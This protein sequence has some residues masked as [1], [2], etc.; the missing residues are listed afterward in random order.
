[1][2][3]SRFSDSQIMA[4]LKQAEND[5]AVSTLCREH[6]MKNSRGSDYRPNGN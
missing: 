2:K 3:R 5:T 4:M 6:G 1:M